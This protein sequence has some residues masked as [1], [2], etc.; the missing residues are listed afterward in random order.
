[1]IWG[2]LY[3]LLSRGV[4]I[5]YGSK[6]NSGDLLMAAQVHKVQIEFK[7]VQTF[8]FSIPKFRPMLG[9]NVLLGETLRRDLY[10][11]AI[12]S[13]KRFFPTNEV[14]KAAFDGFKLHEDDP[15]TPSEE[16][17]PLVP[18]TLEHAWAIDDPKT[19]YGHGI[20]A[21]DGGHFQVL[22]ACGESAHDFCKAAREKIETNM[23]T[24]RFEIAVYSWD[25]EK[26]DW[27]DQEPVPDA[28]SQTNELQFI[29]AFSQPCQLSGEGL[30]SEEL[31][32]SKASDATSVL[33]S[34]TAKILLAKGAKFA[35][36]ETEDIVGLLQRSAKEW[37]CGDL[38]VPQDLATLAG[39]EGR[40]IALIHADGNSVGTRSQD[41][42]AKAKESSGKTATLDDWIKQEAAIE[43]F[44]YGMRVAVRKATMQ[45]LKTVFGDHKG[46][47]RPFQI[48]ML[49]GDDLLMVCQAE[50]ALPLIC[51]YA[52]ELE[53][54]TLADDKTL[55]IGAGI[56]ISKP[57]MPIHA[58]HAMAEELASSAKRR[59]RNSPETSVVDWMIAPSV[60][61]IDLEAYR[62]EH[63]TRHYKVGEVCETLGLSCKP[64]LILASKTTSETDETAAVDGQ[65]TPTTP[66]SATKANL[67][68]VAGLLNAEK[69]LRKNKSE[70]ARSQ[71]K[72]LPQQLATGRRAGQTAYQN[73]PAA[74]RKVLQE[75]GLGGDVNC[76][77]SQVSSAPPNTP[78]QW[79]TPLQDL[80][81]V[82]EIPLLGTRQAKAPKAGEPS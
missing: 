58:L 45:A 11:L 60:G 71:L 36:N 79:I 17:A 13:D 8:L 66:D 72:S 29:P 9:A 44:Y 3:A 33:V 7:R 48:L 80:L 10:L 12:G 42:L 27:K 23:P 49:G 82:Y 25:A 37:P 19:A 50:Y 4:V 31:Q 54:I 43:R 53:K 22:F 76:P 55:G 16:R 32:E 20:L 35:N 34:S 56:V 26:G 64:Y 14:I 59:A 15:L 46:S 78:Q 28:A 62:R 81:E 65:T 70:V 69:A 5:I 67:T 24:L 74:V 73:L 41:I 57:S 18:P 30:A 6:K 63:L 68:S 52:A 2:S 75:H 40:Y 51:A 47:S 61:V 77:W 21:R 38:V 39:G 1:M